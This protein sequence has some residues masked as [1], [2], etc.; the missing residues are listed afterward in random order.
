MNYYNVQEWWK[1]KNNI[2]ASSYICKEKLDGGEHKR[3]TMIIWCNN[4][5]W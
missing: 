1:K 3:D 5:G 2:L 4:K